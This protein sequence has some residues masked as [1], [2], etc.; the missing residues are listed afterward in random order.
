MVW[1]HVG[2]LGAQSSVMCESA[3]DAVVGVGEAEAR[4]CMLV[5]CEGFTTLVV[6]GTVR[7]A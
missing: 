1:L 3:Y 5:W 2:G 6:H 4:H 7:G